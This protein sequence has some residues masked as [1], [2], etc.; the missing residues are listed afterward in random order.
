MAAAM[1]TTPLHD[2][3]GV[4]STI[5][6]LA[7]TVLDNSML[8][9]EAQKVRKTSR[10]ICCFSPIAPIPIDGST[11]RPAQMVD[12]TIDDNSTTIIEDD[13]DD[14]SGD[15]S[16]KE[17]W[18]HLFMLPANTGLL[19]L[20]DQAV[21]ADRGSI[22][23]RKTSADIEYMSQ[24]LNSRKTTP[25]PSR[26][27][28]RIDVISSSSKSGL[29]VMLNKLDKFQLEFSRHLVMLRKYYIRPLLS[30]AI[31]DA[32]ENVEL[33]QELLKQGVTACHREELPKRIQLS[34]S[35][36]KT[37]SELFT[38][39][40]Q[41]AH[42]HGELSNAIEVVAN[43]AVSGR[44]DYK[45]ISYQ[46]QRIDSYYMEFTQNHIWA[47]QNFENLV[48][49][50]NKVK[51]AIRIL[52]SKAPSN[53]RNL[54]VLLFSM[55]INWF[56]KFAE[57]LHQIYLLCME[58]ANL[59]P[60]DQSSHKI[61]KQLW[62][63]MERI[64]DTQ[65]AALLQQRIDGLTE[66]LVGSQQRLLHMALVDVRNTTLAAMWKPLLMVILVDRIFF[67]RR[68]TLDTRFK[69]KYCIYF[70]QTSARFVQF[71]RAKSYGLIFQS[72]RYHELTVRIGSKKLLRE[73][74]TL[75]KSLSF[76]VN[77]EISVCEEVIHMEISSMISSNNVCPTMM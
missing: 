21:I 20:G 69:I 19:Y 74:Q 77:D 38:H 34:R 14:G 18:H 28:S 42:E 48:Y 72:P 59:M 53:H 3:S 62:P 68:K 12:T 55:H 51:D 76:P 17:R 35:A 22:L 5:V 63:F 9:E 57:D 54:R 60:P 23:S 40:P 43:E 50:D 47:L 27:P 44:G 30:L 13:G 8:A 61:A 6:T 45:R 67:L 10:P 26:L 49:S 1:R 39:I 2:R 15:P 7:D 71:N 24:A 4:A 25:V 41:L 58:R 70:N 73:W 66:P 75:T 32:E 29:Y 36:N 65:H 33:A 46:M 52:E 37:I 64:A 11:K 16:E 56:W 31:K